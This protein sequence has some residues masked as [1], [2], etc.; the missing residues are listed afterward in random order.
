VSALPWFRVYHRMVDDER[1]RL[2]AFEDRWHFVAVLCLKADGL[3]DDQR[4]DL[5]ERRLALKL[6]LQTRELEELQRRLMGV[7]LI[8]AYWQP[9]KWDELQQRSDSSTERT[10]KYRER[11][12]EQQEQGCDDV[13]RHGDVTVT[14]QI[15]ED[16]IREEEPKGSRASGDTPEFDVNDFVDSWNETA[17]ACGLSQIRKL[18]DARKR[19]FKARQ[20]EYPDMEDWQRAFACLRQNKWMH[21]ENKTGWRADPAFFLNT[22]KFTKLVEGQYGQA[23]R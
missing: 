18:T 3:I 20:R 2:L 15:R 6:G 1:L 4:G 14:P 22:E 11:Q 10:R 9:V 16:K 12:K 5:W 23:D 21:G 13:K 17:K 8:D 19:A 7:G